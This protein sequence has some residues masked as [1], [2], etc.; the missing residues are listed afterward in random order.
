MPGTQRKHGKG[1]RSKS[2]IGHRYKNKLWKRKE[3][4]V[5][6]S[7]GLED[8]QES[9]EEPISLEDNNWP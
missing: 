3:T 1:S 4:S 9:P 8:E 6:V 2:H 7:A 5:P